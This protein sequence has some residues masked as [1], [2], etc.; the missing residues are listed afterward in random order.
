MTTEKTILIAEDEKTT[1]NLLATALAQPGRIVIATANGTEA[2]EVMKAQTVD[3]LI[4][5]LRMPIMDGFTLIALVR[6]LYPHVP[7]LAMTAMDDAEHQDFP[8][9]LGAHSL[10]PKPLRL[11][12]VREAVDQLLEHAPARGMAEGMSL[13]GILQL[14]GMEHQHATLEIT[15]D[16][17]RGTLYVQHGEIIHAACGELEGLDAAYELLAWDQPSVSFEAFC[18]A[19]RT[20]H[21][22]LLEILMRA[23][24][25]RDELAGGHYAQS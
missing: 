15:A 9:L 16:G 5:D 17:R 12:L 13:E 23:A 2:L 24:H 25:H 8:T 20:I 1:R 14:I 19:E 22:P 3:V 6:R 11:P 4:T 21:R 10:F 18:A 7:I